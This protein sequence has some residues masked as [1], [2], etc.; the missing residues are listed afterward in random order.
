MRLCIITRQKFSV[1]ETFIHAHAKLLPGVQAV[2]HREGRRPIITGEPPLTTSVARRAIGRI[3]RLGRRSPCSQV[4]AAYLE[5]FRRHRPDVLLVEYGTNGVEVMDAARIA[6][7]PF[8]V[9]FH[10]ADATR[11][12]VL[13]KLGE[14]YRQMF[15]EAAS[16]IVV[17]EQMRAQLV[18]LGA[19]E[20]KLFC[21][22][23]GV[24]TELFSQAAPEHAPPTLLAVG[25]LT[26]KKAPHLLLLAFAKARQAY[27]S[28]RLIVVGDGILRGVCQDIAHERGIADAVEFLG[29]QPHH[30][31]VELMKEARAFVQHSIEAY[32]G[33]CEG[34]P[35]AVL[36][37]SASGLPVISTRHAGIPEAVLHGQTGLLVEERDVDGMAEHM[38]ML[39]QNPRLAGELGRAARRHVAKNYSMEGSIA[40][41]ASILQSASRSLLNET[42]AN[43]QVAAVESAQV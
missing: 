43:A 29:A 4:T 9:H 36:E 35:V 31:V 7:I 33:D 15:E 39:A 21:N 18:R 13:E 26:E 41:L 1:S 8:V 11:H 24:D 32:D 25:R 3:G 6:G 40:R 23:C 34:M 27:S 30:R 10:G 19:P 17:S 38:I 2:I 28:L 5:A 37:A 14:R 42:E 12:W 22:S 20:N 16:I